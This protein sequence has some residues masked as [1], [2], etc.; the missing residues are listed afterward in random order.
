MLLPDHKTKIVATIGPASDSPAMLERLLRAG[1]NVARLNF[2]HGDLASHG[3][4]IARIRAAEKVTGRR[5]AIM[6][7][8]PGPKMRLGRIEPGP[9]E[10]RAGESFTLTNE[11]IVGN[12]Q[13]VATNFERLPRVVKPGNRLFLNDGLVQ[14]VVEQ[15]Q[16]SEV[17]CR[18]AVGGELRSRKGLN[19]PGIDLGISAFTAHDRDCLEFALRAGVDAIS[20]SFVE[21]AADMEAVRAAASALGK[22]PFLIAKIERADALRHLDDI[23]KA[24]DGIMVA[25]GDLG[26]EVPIQEMAV[27]QKQLIA[28]ASLVGKPVITATQMLESMVVNRLPTRAESTDVANAILDGTD[29]IMLSGESAMGHYPEEAVAM[30]A[31]I[32]AF[33]EAHR[34]PTRLDDLWALSSQRQPATTAEAIV[35]VVENALGSVPCAAVFVPTWTGTT[36]R[37]I[38]RFNPAVWVVAISQS[39]AVC[40]GLAFSYGVQ[41]VQLAEDPE[42]WRAF[43][44]QWLREHRLPGAVAMLVAGPSRRHPEANYRIEF[45]RVNDAPQPA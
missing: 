6:A 9:I 45:L 37:M 15:V 39:A 27:L 16:G 21:T 12:R 32:A 43:A 40:Q 7:D 36:A 13:R 35:S 19:L 25:R 34:P 29:C 14:L 18:V 30:L 20:Q 23:L 1:M 11:D 44:R 22:H 5:V 17:H 28:R 26:V 2:S 33:T 41:A 4:R 3:E 42:D 10:L 31:K 24:T 8:L 38:S